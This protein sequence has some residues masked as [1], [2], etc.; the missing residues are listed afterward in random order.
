[1][2]VSNEGGMGLG[3]ETRLGRD[4][5]DAQGELNRAVAAVCRRVEFMVAGLPLTVKPA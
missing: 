1:M 3:P 2:R 5:R 4:C